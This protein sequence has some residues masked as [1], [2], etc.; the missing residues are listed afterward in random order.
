M[1]QLLLPGHDDEFLHSLFICV[2]VSLREWNVFVTSIGLSNR[3]FRE[4]EDY[5]EHF[6]P[7]VGNFL[8][9]LQETRYRQRYLDLMVNSDI[10][11]VFKA[12][13]QVVSY[14]RRF[15]DERDF[16]EVSTPGLAI[17]LCH[18]CGSVKMWKCHCCPPDYVR[19]LRGRALNVGY[20][21]NSGFWFIF[22]LLLF[23]L[24]IFYV[25]ILLLVWMLHLCRYLWLR[26]G[27]H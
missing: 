23:L 9:G 26:A 24:L 6:G 27:L 11:K 2:W 12:R 1:G 4:K 25:F 13:S 3:A 19:A 10:R 15:F 22:L 7:Y 16:V 17:Y 8:D 5:S 20:F 21:S 18:S 14:I